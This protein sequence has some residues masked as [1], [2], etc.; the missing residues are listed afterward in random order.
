MARAGRGNWGPLL[1]ALV[2]EYGANVREVFPHSHQAAL[3]ER[4]RSREMKLP[5]AALVASGTWTRGWEK[6]GAIESLVEVTGGH[7]NVGSRI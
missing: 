7:P 6:A 2:V 4:P 1:C 3:S 5:W